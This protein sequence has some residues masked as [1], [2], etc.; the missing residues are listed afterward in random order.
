MTSLWE[1]ILVS[2]VVGLALI[3][4]VRAVYRYI[5]GDKTCTGCGSDGGCGGS[6][7]RDLVQDLAPLKEK[8]EEAR[9]RESHKSSS[10]D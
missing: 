5:R 2:V 3:W 7:P 10:S 8:V 6:S 1:S 4:A 9:L